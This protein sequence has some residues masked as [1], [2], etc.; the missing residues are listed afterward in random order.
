MA[1]SSWDAEMRLKKEHIN[2]NNICKEGEI[3]ASYSRPRHFLI[4]DH[5]E[6]FFASLSRERWRTCISGTEHT[7]IS[8][9][10]YV[11]KKKANRAQQPHTHIMSLERDRSSF[12]CIYCLQDRSSFTRMWIN[13]S[14]DQRTWREQEQKEPGQNPE[15][16]NHQELRAEH[17][18]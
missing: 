13:R 18:F 15:R 6:S 9:G 3:A 8:P 12:C 1:G 5:F 14:T 2:D 10:D 7:L 16:H 11:S 17:A 4:G